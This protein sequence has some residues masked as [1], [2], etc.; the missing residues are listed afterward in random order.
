MAGVVGSN[1]TRPIFRPMVLTIGVGSG[2][3]GSGGGSGGHFK[4]TSSE[5]GFCEG[6]TL[7]GG[8]GAGGKDAFPVGHGG[9]FDCSADTGECEGVDVGGGG[10]KSREQ[11]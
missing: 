7:S 2:S 11:S 10:G 6:A 5:D 8:G 1:P 4:R 3:P 9:H